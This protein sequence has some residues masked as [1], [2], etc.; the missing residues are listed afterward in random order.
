MAGMVVATAINC[1]YFSQRGLGGISIRAPTRLVRVASV[2]RTLGV[3]LEF[4][5]TTVA[6]GLLTRLSG[7]AARKLFAALIFIRTTQPLCQKLR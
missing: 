5:L 3:T 6:P 4:R 1:S 2:T 7:Y